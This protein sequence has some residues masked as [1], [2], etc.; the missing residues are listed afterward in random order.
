MSDTDYINENM[1]GFSDDG[2]PNFLNSVNDKGGR[3]GYGD[4]D[5]AFYYLDRKSFHNTLYAVTMTLKAVNLLPYLL[6]ENPDFK[7]GRSEL[8][9]V[10]DGWN[11][12]YDTLNVVEESFPEYCFIF[13]HPQ[14]EI[15]EVTFIKTLENKASTEKLYI[16]PDSESNES[17]WHFG[18]FSS[19]KRFSETLEEGYYNPSINRLTKDQFDTY[20]A[21]KVAMK[22]V[23]KPD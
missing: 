9:G 10:V 1:G 11:E 13:I 6:G 4:V 3:D 16:K 20:I 19:L 21:H 18:L 5:Y 17:K 14:E 12:I 7:E 8:Q 22:G 23:T 2:L 15:L